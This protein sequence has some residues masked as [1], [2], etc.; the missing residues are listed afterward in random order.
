[1]WR[2]MK[3]KVDGCRILRTDTAFTQ[4]DEKIHYIDKAILLK[5]KSRSFGGSGPSLLGDH[6]HHWSAGYAEPVEEVI[7]I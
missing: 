3:L 5:D 4:K 2:K 1:M 7:S 6:N